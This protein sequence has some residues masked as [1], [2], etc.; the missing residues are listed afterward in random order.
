MGCWFLCG[1]RR[2]A[3]FQG[4]GEVQE[5]ALQEVASLRCEVWSAEE[6][7][8]TLLSSPSKHKLGSVLKC[9]SQAVIGFNPRPQLRTPYYP[10]P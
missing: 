10:K 2:E 9:P 7:D 6:Y 5:E 4:V 3:V 1:A 8:R